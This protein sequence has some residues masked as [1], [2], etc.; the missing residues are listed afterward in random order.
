MSASRRMDI[1]IVGGG[2]IGLSCAWEMARRGASVAVYDAGTPEHAASWA[3]AGMLAPAYEQLEAGLHPELASLCM[4]SAHLWQSF[5]A[6][7]Q[8]ESSL[9]VGYISG[10]SLAVAVTPEQAEALSRLGTPPLGSE[11][12]RVLVAPLSEEVV[13]AARLP[14][15]GWVD[16]RKTLGALHAALA[17]RG[18]AIRNARIDTSSNVLDPYDKVLFATGAVPDAHVRPVKGVM[19]AVSRDDVPVN[20]VV[21]CGGE[22]AVPRGDRVLIGATV[23]EVD[24]PVAYLVRRASMFLPDV[25]TAQILDRWHGYRPATPDHA[26]CLGRMQTPGHYMA[27]GHYRNGILLAPITARIMADM[28]LDGRVS[29]E[30]RTFSPSRF[31]V[32]T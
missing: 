25:A 18:V 21:R 9:D 28:M 23:G 27:K 22:Y 10:P 6:E 19:F 20:C 16:N 8:A 24:D 1:A 5:A 29:P 12:A 7:L 4:K 3:A 15:D 26:P 30:A 31:A 11:E 13:H 17:D 14:T 32:T 2:I